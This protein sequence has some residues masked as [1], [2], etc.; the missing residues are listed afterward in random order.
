[1]N[2]FLSPSR[3]LVVSVVSHGHGPLVQNLLN[4]LA[5][6]SAVTIVRVVL[7]QNL[8]EAE[9]EAPATGWPFVLQVVRNKV[10]VGFGAN[11]NRAL[12]GATEPFV[13]VLN[14]DV[15]LNGQDPFAALAQAAGQPGV[16]C[17]YPTQL[18]ERGHLQDSERELPTPRALWRRRF[19]G[20]RETR[21]DWVN[22]ACLV[23]PQAVWQAVRGFD[24]AYFMYCEDVD[25]CLRIRL[26]GWALVRVPVQ[27]VHVGQRASHRRWR[28][29]QWHVRSLVRLWRSPVYGQA[30]L[31]LRGGVAGT[32]TIGRS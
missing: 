16:G 21:V 11:H 18:D 24:E 3:S 7:T 15:G 25:L 4:D 27:V 17:A 13:C 23:L 29:L 31:L 22:A 30:C 6:L 26:A 8:P 19:L 2:A 12:A 1:M 10:P 5:R 32:G 20:C 28:H 9:P 14:P